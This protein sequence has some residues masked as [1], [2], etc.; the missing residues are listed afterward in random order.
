MTAQLAYLDAS[1][2]TKL[3]LPERESP[4]V[5]QLIAGLDIVSSEIA[6][7]EVR[8]ALLR[9]GA[10][11]KLAERARIVLAGVV[12][13]S[14]DSLI[15]QRAASIAPGALKTLDAIHLATALRLAPDRVLFVGYD[16]RLNAAARQHGLDVNAPEVADL[17]D[18]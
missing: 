7:I 18:T 12:F 11:P 14:I 17:Y 9:L 3:V 5:E 8:R 13:L 2:L 6:S 16:K 4:A 1:A 10:S 15:V